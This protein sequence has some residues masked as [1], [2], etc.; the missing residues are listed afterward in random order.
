MANAN[1]SNFDP[2]SAYAKLSERVENQGSQLVDLRS[3]VNTGFQ[4]INAQLTQLS[5][6]L[7]AN[8]KTPWTVIW[9]A[10]GVS[11]AIIV[12]IGGLAYAPVTSGIGRVEASIASL[13]ERTVTRQEM[14]WRQARSQEDRLRTDASIVD[15]RTH[16]VPRGELDRVFEAYDEQLRDK[17]RQ[18]DEVKAAQ[19][20][21]YG[22]RDAMMDMRDRVDRLEQRRIMAAP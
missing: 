14:D 1:G 8:D 4:Q 21:I 18:I 22:A 9:S 20:S 6:E 7:R 17:Q 11:F 10:I 13:S 12:A 3:N 5:G 15:L 2:M 16:Q 19:A